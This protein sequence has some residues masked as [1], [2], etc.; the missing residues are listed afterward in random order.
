M[1][2][3]HGQQSLLQ[4]QLRQLHLRGLETPA[5]RRPGRELFR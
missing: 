3:K 1:W 5:R 4:R 2:R